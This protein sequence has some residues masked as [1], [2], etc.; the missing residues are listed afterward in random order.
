MAD[1]FGR[2]SLSGN[3]LTVVEEQAPSV[4]L[5]QAR[6]G[7]GG[8]SKVTIIDADTVFVQ[9]RGSPGAKFYRCG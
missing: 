4:Q 3:T 9:W 8:S 2:W 5:F 1:G 7:D 6:L